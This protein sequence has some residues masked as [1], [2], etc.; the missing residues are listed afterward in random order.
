MKNIQKGK[1]S[2]QQV[3]KITIGMRLPIEEKLL[4]VE[5]LLNTQQ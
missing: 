5:Y 1:I 3:S 2:L 4:L